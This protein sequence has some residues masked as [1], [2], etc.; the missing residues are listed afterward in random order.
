M[1]CLWQPRRGERSESNPQVRF[2]EG[3]WEE[4]LASQAPP[5]ALYS[6]VITRASREMSESIP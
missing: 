3:E 1:D 4:G 2:D 6:T 5:V